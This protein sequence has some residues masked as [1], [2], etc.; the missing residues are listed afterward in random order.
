MYVYGKNAKDIYLRNTSSF[1]FHFISFTLF[2]K[3]ALTFINIV[4][5]K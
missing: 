1:F 2:K 4:K 5:S 3:Y